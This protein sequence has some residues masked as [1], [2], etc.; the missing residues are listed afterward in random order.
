MASQVLVKM[1]RDEIE[2][3]RLLSEYKYEVDTRSRMV[4]AKREGR[5]EGKAERQ[6]G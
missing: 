1:S 6:K 2:R 4:E 5:L 3:A